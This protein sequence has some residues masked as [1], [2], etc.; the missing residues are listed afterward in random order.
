VSGR[1]WGFEF[2]SKPQ[3]RLQSLV[4][5]VIVK[6]EFLESPQRTHPHRASSVVRSTHSNA[7]AD[8]DSSAVS[9]HVVYLPVRTSDASLAHLSYCK[10]TS[11]ATR[12]NVAVFSLLVY[13]GTGTTVHPV[14]QH[15]LR[16]RNGL[17]RTSSL[18]TSLSC[19]CCGLTDL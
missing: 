13:R 14:T 6:I 18:S 8:A 1:R 9:V 19:R 10:K 7:C 15:L 3:R 4:T 12:L 16:R 5:R 11:Y 2:C 17:S